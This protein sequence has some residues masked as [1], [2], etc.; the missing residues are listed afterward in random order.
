MLKENDVLR[1]CERTICL[2]TAVGGFVLWA[3][4]LF[5][6]ETGSPALAVRPP[7]QGPPS[8]RGLELHAPLPV[9]GIGQLRGAYSPCL[10]AD[11]KTL[12]FANWRSAKTGY[13]LYLATRESVDAPFGP[14]KRIE[15]TVTSWTDAYPALSPNGLDLVYVSSDDGHAEK[16]H[17][18]MRSKRPDAESPFSQSEEFRLTRI[19]ASRWR[20]ASP[21]FLDDLQ[22]KFC[23][24]ESETVRSVRIASRRNAREPFKTLELLPLENHWPIW[25]ISSDGMRAYTGIDQGICL[26]YRN[27]PLDEFG[28]MHVIV[29]AK[30]IGK[31]DGPI[32]VAPQEDVL[33]YCSPTEGR[34]LMMVAF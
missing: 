11:L 21:Q 8:V 18:L 29:P 6:Q 30:I 26:A 25:W 22:L 1:F 24:I 13:D 20:V 15:G 7:R 14:A 3:G 10:T 31:V 9:P 17:K 32:W 34:H 23:L 2:A 16:K 5:A 4:G 28:P 27:S 33:F 19:D 12:V